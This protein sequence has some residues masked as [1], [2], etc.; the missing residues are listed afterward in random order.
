MKKMR[1]SE[2]NKEMVGD[3]TSFEFI[4]EVLGRDEAEIAFLDNREREIDERGCRHQ[5]TTK[6]K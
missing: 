3:K 1:A 4:T 5:G 6:D 2:W